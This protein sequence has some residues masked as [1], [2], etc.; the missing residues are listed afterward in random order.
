M[1]G[2]R[3]GG[4]DR[5]GDRGVVLDDQY[6]HRESSPDGD[7]CMFSRARRVRLL[8]TPAG[9]EGSPIRLWMIVRRIYLFDRMSRAVG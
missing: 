9:P 2:A 6:A 5:V 3:E 1:A 7:R 4:D 8:A